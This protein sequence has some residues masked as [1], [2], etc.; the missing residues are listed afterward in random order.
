MGRFSCGG[1]TPVLGFEALV[2]SIGAAPRMR[3]GS[4]A[5]GRGNRLGRNSG[6][7]VRERLKRIIQFGSRA[8]AKYGGDIVECA[9]GSELS[10]IAGAGHPQH[11]ASS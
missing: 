11:T 3:G 5:R 1:L 9:D 8:E 10:V 4:G 6:D 2:R 7:R